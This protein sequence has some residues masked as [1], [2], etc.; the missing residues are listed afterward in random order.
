MLPLLELRNELDFRTEESRARDRTRRDFRRITGRLSNYTDK[1][2]NFRLVPGPY[3]Q[4]AR[5]YWLKRLLQTQEEVRTRCPEGTGHIELITPDELHEIRRIWVIEKHETEDLLPAIYSETTGRTYPGPAI[6][7]HRL[8]DRQA[9]E[10]LRQSVGGDPLRYELCRNL[11]DIERRYRTMASRRGLFSALEDEVR[12]CYYRDEEDALSWAQAQHEARHGEPV[13]RAEPE[14]PDAA[15]APSSNGRYAADATPLFSAT[16]DDAGV[17][18][19]GEA[20]A[21]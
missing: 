17:S 9:L 11:L 18:G 4:E 20:V 13:P 10:L 2:G 8:F 1:D 7:D 14:A 16:T 6:D 3:T 5:A 21:E 19:A 12:R 15:K